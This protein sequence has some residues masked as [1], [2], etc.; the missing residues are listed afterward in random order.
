MCG[1]CMDLSIRF[2]TAALSS[3]QIR[4]LLLISRP[5]HRD[6][7]NPTVPK[8]QY[9]EC[10]SD[11]VTELQYRHSSTQTSPALLSASTDGLVNLLALTADNED[12]ALLLSVNHRSALHHAGLLKDGQ[13][14]YALGTDETLSF[15]YLEDP[16][17][18]SSEI[19]PQ[20]LGDIRE[21]LS[22][23]YVIGMAQAN[24]KTIMATGHY[25]YLLSSHPSN[26]RFASHED[27]C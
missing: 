1:K 16:D 12:D 26:C 7:R 9:L 24:G 5:R 13:E 3:S 4:Y 21:S 22:C 14:V 27:K 19:Q 17:S 18:T 8:A 11:T 10:H 20:L 23:E 2:E 25:R 6:P 15:Y